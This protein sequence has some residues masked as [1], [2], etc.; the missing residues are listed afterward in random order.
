VADADGLLTPGLP[1]LAVAE[2]V[3]HDLQPVVHVCVCVCVCVCVYIYIYVHINI[4]IY[5]QIYI[6]IYIYIRFQKFS[7]VLGLDIAPRSTLVSRTRGCPSDGT[8]NVGAHFSEQGNREDHQGGA[9]RAER[10]ER[11]QNHHPAH[12]D[13]DVPFLDLID[14][15]GLV[16]APSGTEPS[17]IASQTEAVVKAHMQS[18]QGSNSLY[19]AIVKATSDPNTSSNAMKILNEAKLYGKT[20]GVF[21]FCDELNQRNAPRLKQWV[22]NGQGAVVLDPYGW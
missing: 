15:P 10:S 19:L 20:S 18:M 14:M 22:R 2:R 9:G 17:D 1:R 7:N 6:S 21:T 5:I 13:P 8:K 4:Y 3:E 11:H 12:L 16:T